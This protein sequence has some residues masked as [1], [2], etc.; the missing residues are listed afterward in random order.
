MQIGQSSMF[1]TIRAGKKPP[2]EALRVFSGALFPRRRV[3]A[4]PECA[5][6]PLFASAKERP[7]HSPFVVLRPGER[8]GKK[9]D[10]TLVAKGPV[11]V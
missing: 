6:R 1:F 11:K 7:S 3:K 5:V 2:N 4:F 9:R 10:K 8:E